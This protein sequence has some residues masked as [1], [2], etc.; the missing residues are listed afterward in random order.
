MQA[1]E[2]AAVCSAMAVAQTT[3]SVSLRLEN[4]PRRN[5][6]STHWWKWV[7]YAFFS[8]RARACSTVETLTLTF[9]VLMD[10]EDIERFVSVLTSDHP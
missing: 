6:P 5:M 3:K 9:I 7:A 10:T 2:F 1:H 8:K 4:F